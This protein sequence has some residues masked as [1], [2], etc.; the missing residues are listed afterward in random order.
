M[1]LSMADGIAKTTVTEFGVMP[2]G[3]AIQRYTVKSGESWASFINFG[4]RI[5]AL[6]VPDS[7]GR[8]DN[9]VLGYETLEQ[10]LADRSF[11]GAAIGRVGNRIAGGQF[12]VEGKTYQ[13]PQ[14]NGPNALH[15]GPVGF[16]Q[17]VWSGKAIDNGV[18]FTLVSPDGDQGF[19]GALTV[20]VRYTFVEDALR[21]EYSATCDATTVVNLTNHSFF[22]L[23]GDSSGSI[24]D[25]EIAIPAEFFTPVSEV[26][27]PTGQLAPVDGTA[28]DL[29][30]QVRVGD[31]IDDD[32]VQLQRAGGWDHNWALGLEGE[33]KLAARLHSPASGRTMTV[34]TTEPGIQFYSGNF[35][36]GSMPNR[37]GGRYKKRDGLCLETQHYPD[38]PNQ[39]E[40]PSTILKPGET[41]RSV[42]TYSFSVR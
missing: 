10:Y 30:E 24:L 16:D 6:A 23:D 39:P 41:L 38:S 40:F 4:A 22:N 28:F 42:T 19:P 14:N 2:D 32:D 7:E 34:A 13:I 3:T 33:M 35:L 8:C 11:Q 37:R 5:L 31:H 20:T 27:I 9:V 12:S 21:I 1:L 17:K 36:D 18:E 25:H 26:L 29:R 15:G